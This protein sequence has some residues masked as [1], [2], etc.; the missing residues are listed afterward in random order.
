MSGSIRPKNGDLFKRHLLQLHLVSL[1][2]IH[3]EMTES[4]PSTK[5]VAIFNQINDRV[6]SFVEIESLMVTMVCV[7]GW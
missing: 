5:L 6:I 2:P 4:S 1:P 7:G 3:L